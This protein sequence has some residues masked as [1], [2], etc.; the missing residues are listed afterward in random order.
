MATSWHAL[1]LVQ[2]SKSI[3]CM[4]TSSKWLMTSSNSEE[5]PT[6]GLRLECWWLSHLTR[7]TQ[8]FSLISLLISQ[9]E[10]L[11]A[12]SSKT[13]LLVQITLTQ[14]LLIKLLQLL[15][16][17]K[18]TS[19]MWLSWCLSLQECGMEAITWLPCKH[20]LAWLQLRRQRSSIHWTQPRLVLP[21]LQCVTPYQPNTV[22]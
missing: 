12:T 7:P 15:F 10:I 14:L 2:R 13:P 19:K 8:S 9:Q 3:L 4:D 17:R 5:D 22:A 11:Q 16:A 6:M 20:L 18:T 21:F 1:L